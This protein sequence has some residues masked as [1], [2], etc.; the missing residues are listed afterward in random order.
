[1]KNDKTTLYKEKGEKSI[2]AHK[3]WMI[4]FDG[5]QICFIYLA[6]IIIIEKSILKILV[7]YQQFSDSPAISP[8]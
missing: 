4:I 6:H 3:I 7:F 5:S 1:M 2:H 8:L